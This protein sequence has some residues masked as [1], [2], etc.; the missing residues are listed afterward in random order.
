MAFFFEL[1]ALTRN[2]PLRQISEQLH[3]QNSRCSVR[4]IPLLNVFDGI[5][6]FGAR[7]PTRLRL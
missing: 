3:F 7:W 2:T 5:T 4:M 6:V 1:S